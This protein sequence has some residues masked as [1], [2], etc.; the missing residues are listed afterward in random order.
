MEDSP[1]QTLD[2][3]KKQAID[4]FYYNIDLACWSAISVGILPSIRFISR[5]LSIVRNWEYSKISP[6]FLSCEVTCGKVVEVID[7]VVK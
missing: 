5:N 7:F 4:E 6:L 3:I 1:S 2:K